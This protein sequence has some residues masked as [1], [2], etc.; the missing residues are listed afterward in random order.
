[1]TNLTLTSRRK[2]GQELDMSSRG[3]IQPNPFW[4]RNWI[5][6]YGYSN[7][8]ILMFIFI[9]MILIYGMNLFISSDNRIDN[10]IN[11]LHNVVFCVRLRD[12]K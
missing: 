3:P 1:M 9:F 7:L 5:G 4:K 12:V 2:N 6:C 11:S 8:F 10:T